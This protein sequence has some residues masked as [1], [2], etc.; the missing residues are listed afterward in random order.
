MLRTLT[1]LLV[2]AVLGLVVTVLFRQ[3]AGGFLSEQ[4]DISLASYARRFAEEARERNV[5]VDLSDLTLVFTDEM[6]VVDGQSFCGYAFNFNS[7]SPP[8]V[9]I[10]RSCW[11][12]YSDEQREILVFHELGHALLQRAHHNDYLPSGSLAS[13]MNSV[14]TVSVYDSYTLV[15]RAYYLDELFGMADTLPVWATSRTEVERWALSPYYPGDTSWQFRRE[16]PAG[17]AFGE[18]GADS[19]ASR[20]YGLKVEVPAGAPLDAPVF[21]RHI[22]SHPRIEVGSKVVL[23]ARVRLD[24]VEGP[25]IALAVRGE[26]FGSG[27]T[28]LNVSTKKDE[29]LSGTTGYREMTL[30]ATDYFPAGV[31]ALYIYLIVLPGTTGTAWFDE[32]VLEHS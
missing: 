10:A 15:K 11:E 29:A 24:R 13:L 30:V 25:G 6:I 3:P 12:E 21:W 1:V 17:P 18:I 28:R 9:E 8:Y 22:K 4:V 16:P 27:E 31:N 7:D 2:L 19:S 32:I 23:R 5:S 26:H 14:N 20:V